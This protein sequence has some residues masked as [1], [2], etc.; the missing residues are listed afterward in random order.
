M[1]KA[2][3][4]SQKGIDQNLVNYC[5]S[6]AYT[7]DKDPENAF[8]HYCVEVMGFED[9]HPT[10]HRPIIDKLITKK[11][12]KMIQAARGTF[13]SSIAVAGYVSHCLAKEFIETG[14]SKLR[15]LLASEVLAMA[16][17]NLR[18]VKQTLAINPTYRGLFGDFV[19]EKGWTDQ[20]I[21]SSQRIDPRYAEPTVD[22]IGWGGDKTGMH[23]D[24]IVC[25]DLQARRS[26][27]TTEQ[28][29]NVYEFYRLLFSLLEPGGTL[30]LIGT[31]WD[32]D[33]IYSRIEQENLKED[34]GHRF[35]IFKMPARDEHGKPT[36]PTRLPEEELQRLEQGGLYITSADFA[37]TEQRL[38]DLGKV[39]KADYTVVITAVVDETWTY[40]IVDWYRERCTRQEAV[41]ECFRQVKQYGSNVLALQKYDASQM[42]EAF[43]QHGWQVGWQ[44]YIDW[45]TY[46]P[47]QRKNH[48]IEMSLQGLFSQGRI[49]LLRGMT[50]LES[51]LLSFPRGT[52]D[53]LDTL[54]NIVKVSAPG[55]GNTP[56]VRLTDQQVRIKAL[57]AGTWASTE[58]P[59]GTWESILD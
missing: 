37:F 18:K 19:G 17:T 21:F 24:I 29:E 23:Y 43:E 42:R 15:I 12:Y 55:V 7:T 14:E 51:E 4:L 27:T 6:R 39:K 16:R 49:K 25:D 8:Y 11:R 2:R 46:P 57:K 26:V 41:E 33:D 28:I 9:M 56:M 40:R 35:E 53:G 3:S 58:G 5:M 31:R 48:R 32:F 38:I 54:C 50:F 45:V 30:V 22:I 34:K 10:F 36:F 47:N 13:K 52:K 1:K 20:G 59:E 44:P